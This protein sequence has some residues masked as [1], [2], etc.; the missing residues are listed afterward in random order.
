MR[1]RTQTLML[2][3]FEHPKQVIVFLLGAT[4][5]L[6]CF[7]RLVPVEMSAKML[8]IK[9]DPGIAL[10]EDTI[11]T[12][13]SSKITVVL[14]KD[15]R[16]FTPKKLARLNEFQHTLEKIPFVDRVDSLFSISNIKG[17][18]GELRTDP[19]IKRVP[20]SIKKA[21]AIKAEVLNNS[22]MVDNLISADGSALAFN[23]FIDEDVSPDEQRRF[24]K[25]LDEV[26][27]EIS[28]HVHTI[29]QFGSPYL[30]RMFYEGQVSDQR[31][32]IPVAFL[33]CT[34]LSFIIWRSFSLVVMILI[35]SGT[36]IVW[37]LGFMGLF[38]LP[39]NGFTAIMPALLIAI[40]STE[41]THIFSEYLTGFQKTGARR[42]AIYYTIDNIS[43]PLFLT[44]LT[45]F[46][47][48]LAISLNKILIL[49]QFGI[50][51]AFGLFANP[52]ITFLVAPIFLKYFGPQKAVSGGYVTELIDT[53]FN[54]LTRTI[55]HLVDFY[56]RRTFIVITGGILL[57]GLFSLG[58]S[59]ENDIM[60]VFK[61]SSEPVRF[62]RQ[63]N[64]EIASTRNFVIHIKSKTVGAFNE[65]DALARLA[66]IQASMRQ[67]D[68]CD[69]TTSIVDY[70]L[71][72]NREMHDGDETYKT[73]PKS[74]NL[75]A[76]YL[77]IMP[78]EG[79]ET[80]ITN[81]AGEASIVVRYQVKPPNTFQE[82][83]E[84]ASK[85]VEEH[86]TPEFDFHITGESILTMKGSRTLIIGQVLSLSFTLIVVFLLMSML[87][88]GFKAGL[89]S[90]I[91]NVLPIIFLFGIMGLF[92]IPLN[93]GSSMAAV[94]VIGIAVDDTIHFMS[95]YYKERQRL[96]SRDQAIHACIRHE[97]RP[98]TATSLGLAIGFGT[99]MLSSLTPLMHFGFLAASVMLSALI[100]DLLIMPIILKRTLT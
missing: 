28:P 50:V 87:F 16:L 95:C 58:I 89:V 43:L 92:G 62:N 40:G 82:I 70:L 29:F 96:P 46:F 23:I 1:I 48:F 65:P 31:K 98:I 4:F 57:T 45:T 2:W 69:L 27:E 52:L 10:Y 83:I 64:E 18:G 68:W 20:E 5:F 13:G 49:K 33:L 80:F 38:G 94:I 7:I 79:T 37:T 42:E 81:D 12:F 8:W 36:S 76:Q 85:I 24:S 39:M 90:M 17:V 71:V 61:P 26:I 75:I 56:R 100:T 35:T 41:D 88:G 3:S 59:V 66:A 91:P 25:R 78:R 47:G 9:D 14:V 73:I 19:Y 22:L 74:S 53:A 54:G 86:L 84:Q 99:L 93:P 72:M 30:T 67:K 32:I 97:I 55:K 6:S 51:C 15:H 77:L 11:E 60:A 34:L 44:G 21:Q 63:L